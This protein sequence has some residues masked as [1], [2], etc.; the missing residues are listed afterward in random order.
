MKQLEIKTSITADTKISFDGVDVNDFLK[1]ICDIAHYILEDLSLYRQHKNL[2][3]NEF[4]MIEGQ[5]CRL[6]NKLE[7]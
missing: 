5:L 7:D 6:L 2:P 3:D 1:E 4:D